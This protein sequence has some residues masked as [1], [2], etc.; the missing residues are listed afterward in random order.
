MPWYRK[1][2]KDF[3]PLTEAD[4]IEAMN[5]GYFAENLH[6]AYAV[7]LYHTGVRKME[8]LRARKEQFQFNNEGLHFDVGRRLKKGLHTA[9]L[10][11]LKTKPF[12]DELAEAIKNTPPGERVFP[13]SHGTA[14]NIIDRAFD[15]YPHFMRLTKITMLF[16]KGFTID[17]V[18]TWT[19]HKE[20]GSL[21]P[22]VGFANVEE[23]AKA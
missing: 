11:I 16:R 19:G 12:Y 4:F 5:N 10:P 1:H 14:Y 13:F 21:T 3:F 6:R 17:Q 7:L 22:Y 2:G 20:L 15:K 9:P 8:A 23:M 18:R